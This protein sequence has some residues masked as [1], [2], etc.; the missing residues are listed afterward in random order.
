MLNSRLCNICAITLTSKSLARWLE[1]KAENCYQLPSFTI[2]LE[3]RWKTNDVNIVIRKWLRKDC[4]TIAKYYQNCP[5]LMKGNNISKMHAFVIS[6]TPEGENRKVAFLLK[7]NGGINLSENVKAQKVR[8]IGIIKFYQRGGLH[9]SI[10]CRL[11]VC[12]IKLRF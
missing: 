11:E 6:I 2:I 8:D 7:I 12:W 10:C 1:V 4:L 5:I 3:Q 9:E